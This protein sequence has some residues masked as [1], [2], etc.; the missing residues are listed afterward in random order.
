[1]DTG[2]RVTTSMSHFP[3]DD[4]SKLPVMSLRPRRSRLLAVLIGLIALPWTIQ[5]EQARVSLIVQATIAE[6]RHSLHV[7]LLD[8]P[9]R[10]LPATA[11]SEG[12]R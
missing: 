11:P 8:P 9:P 1:M 12:R 5:L 2:L 6:L 10:T 4:S 7:H 3:S